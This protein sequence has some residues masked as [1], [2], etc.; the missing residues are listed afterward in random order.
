MSSSKWWER[1]RELEKLG[2]DIW[3]MPERLKIARDIKA[4]TMDPVWDHASFAFYGDGTEAGSTIIGSAD[5]DPTKG[6]IALDTTFGWRVVINNSGDGNGTLAPKV[7]YLHVDGGN[8]W[9]DANSSDGSGTPVISSASASLTDDE[10]TS[11]RLGGTG[12]FRGGRVDEVDGDTTTADTINFGDHGEW[13]F[14][15]EIDSTQVTED[16]T[17]HLRAVEGDGTV[18][19]NWTGSAAQLATITVPAAAA[20][21]VYENTASA[22]GV[23]T[24]AVAMAVIAGL[25]GVSAAGASA[26]T[27]SDDLLYLREVVPSVSTVAGTSSA[28]VDVFRQ[29]HRSTQAD[30]VSAAAALIDVTSPSG[31]QYELVAAPDGTSTAVSTVFRYAHR[32]TQAG[33]VSTAAVDAAVVRSLAAQADGVATAAV[34]VAVATI[35]SLTAQSD[36]QS[37][38]T[39]DA[40]VIRDLSA[41]ADGQSAAAIAD[42]LLWLREV[43]ASVSSVAGTS[44]AMITAIVVNTSNEDNYATAVGTSSAS[45]TMYTIVPVTMGSVAGVSTATVVISLAKAIA[46]QADGQSGVTLDM[47]VVRALDTQADGVGTATVSISTA[48]ASELTAAP[49]GVSTAAVD[50]FRQAH[51]STSADGTGAATVSVLLIAQRDTQADGTSSAS[52]SVSVIRAISAS[53]D[54]TA[55]ATVS[56]TVVEGTATVTGKYARQHAMAYRLVQKIENGDFAPEHARALANVLK[57]GV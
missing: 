50:V 51:R 36:G 21:T 5:T 39:L 22:A 54:G 35:Y 11:D 4:T 30:G 1:A 34:D 8:T 28:S 48:A 31:T 43:V 33:G 52:V 38:V 45:A 2:H 9:T 18:L 24:V 55:T 12:T 44:T 29:A 40:G 42:D 10:A 19:A 26:A 7:Q 14:S 13:L 3:P 53:A 57:A 23:A 41:S 20:G 16:D 15:L 56:T 27:I 47:A 46:T 25:G 6:D 49:D 17:I 32:D 37:A